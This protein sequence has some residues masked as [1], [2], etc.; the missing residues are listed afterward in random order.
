[1]VTFIIGFLVGSSLVLVYRNNSAKVEKVIE[2]VEDDA[3]SL[4]NKGKAVLEGL[5]GKK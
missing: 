2:E 3:K 1:M 5:K 4:K